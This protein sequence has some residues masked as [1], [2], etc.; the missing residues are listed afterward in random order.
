M[1]VISVERF[2][3]VLDETDPRERA[4][5]LTIYIKLHATKR[6]WTDGAAHHQTA[7]PL[8][9]LGAFALV[10]CFTIVALILLLSVDLTGPGLT[11]PCQS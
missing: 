7:H 6:Q 3:R 1:S 9:V 2:L 8:V 10:A 11:G 5:L 4:N